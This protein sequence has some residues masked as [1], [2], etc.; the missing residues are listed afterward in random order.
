MEGRKQIGQTTSNE[1]GALITALCC[2]DVVGQSLPPALISPRVNF[3]Q[4]NRVQAGSLGLA[5]SSGWM[6]SSIF[7]KYLM[8]FIKYIKCSKAS[9]AV[10]MMDNHES[11]I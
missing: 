5:T 9:P 2:V 1:R 6:N 8:H 7:P 4:F 11:H 3:K 10:L